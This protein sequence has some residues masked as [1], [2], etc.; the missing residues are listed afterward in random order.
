MLL[1]SLTA[2]ILPPTRSYALFITNTSQAAVLFH[3]KASKLGP[4]QGHYVIWDY[5][6]IAVTVEEDE[7]CWAW[8][9]DSRLGMPVGWKVRRARPLMKVKLI[10]C[11]ADYLE[12][13]FRPDLFEQGILPPPLA[14]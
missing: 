11:S 13:T 12:S 3:Q 1:R 4:E 2:R 10:S 6:V 7:S 5:H 14:R 8:D 9:Q